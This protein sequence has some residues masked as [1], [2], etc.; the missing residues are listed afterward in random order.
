MKPLIYFSYGMTKCGTT[1][2][3]H[4]VSEA[5]SQAGCEQHPARTSDRPEQKT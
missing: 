4:M 5:L 1:L 3:F 2:A